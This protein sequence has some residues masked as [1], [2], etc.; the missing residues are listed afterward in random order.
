MAAVPGRSFGGEVIAA[1]ITLH[2]LNDFPGELATGSNKIRIKTLLRFLYSEEDISD[3]LVEKIFDCRTNEG[4]LKGYLLVTID[5]LIPVQP[6][7]ADQSPQN[8][9]NYFTDLMIT[10]ANVPRTTSKIAIG[11]RPAAVLPIPAGG[12]AV[13]PLPPPTITAENIVTGDDIDEDDTFYV[14]E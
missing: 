11:Y 9:E 5:P 13:Q 3:A 1:I 10:I 2:R 14:N 12:G 4:L 7:P 8:L 6:M